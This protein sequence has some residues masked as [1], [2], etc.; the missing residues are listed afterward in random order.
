[1]RCNK[2]CVASIA[3]L[4]WNHLHLTAVRQK[5][6]Y[7]CGVI[8]MPLTLETETKCKGETMTIHVFL[9]DD[10]TVVRDGLRHM[11][12]AQ[13]EVEVVGE[14]DNGLEAVR[15]A[16]R[17]CPDVVVMD[18]AMP[19]MNGTE[20]TQKIQEVSPS[21]QIIILSMYSTTEHIFQALRAGA[22][23]YV[24]KDSAGREVFDAVRA[25]SVGRRYLSQKITEAVV[26]DYVRYHKGASE[27]GPLEALSERE[28]EV[29]Q[30]VA[31]GKT[32]KEAS[33][34]LYLSPK[35]VET[36]RSRLMQKLELDNI[37]ELVR[38]AMQN[39]IIGH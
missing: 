22:L 10:H 32:S 29:L 39:G 23:G 38:F 8:P 13:G 9:A 19:I 26:D 21:T 24:L 4:I 18:I 17:L 35:S 2:L 3:F 27:Q 25:V 31:E 6:Q 28:R 14:A 11:L 7:V 1:M 37:S 5:A 36:Y 33:E 20:A 15:E 30:L 12:E 34:I 16:E